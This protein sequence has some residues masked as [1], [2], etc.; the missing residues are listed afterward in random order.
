MLDNLLR[1][2]NELRSQ[3]S[4]AETIRRLSK[5]Y[6]YSEGHMKKLVT[7]AKKEAAKHVG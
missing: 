4:Y 1:D 3:Y 5:M 7:K 2:Y 6:Y